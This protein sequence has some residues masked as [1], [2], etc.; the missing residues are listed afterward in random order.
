ME[1]LRVIDGGT[2]DIEDWTALADYCCEEAS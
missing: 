2:G 1:C